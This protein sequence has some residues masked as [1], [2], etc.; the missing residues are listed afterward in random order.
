MRQ[1]M[2]AIILAGGKGTRLRPYTITLPKP[3]VPVGDQA[4]LEIVVRQLQV[5]GV[6]RITLAV[7]HMA[8]LLS[9]FFGD[10]NRFGLKIDYSRESV[11]LGTM[12]PLRLI[13]DLPEN[14]L[15]MNGDIL[16]DL[17][18]AKFWDEHERSGA[19]ASVCCYQR[20]VKV[21]FGVLDVSPE[22]FLVGFREKPP[23]THHVSMGIYA[24]RREVLEH[25]PEGKPFGFD[26]LMLRLLEREVPVRCHR[27]SGQWLDIG[28]PDD[29]ER[30]QLLV[31]SQHPPPFEA[32]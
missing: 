12:G 6:G 10:G 8:E 7:S 11:P 32:I 5:A 4:I 31:A 19:I 24:F 20:T 14:F 22:D 21:D 25:I 27:H 26:D 3:L 13:S 17:D 29:Y 2:R 15:V 16:T 28:R 30:A 18:F 9:A 1:P 23:L